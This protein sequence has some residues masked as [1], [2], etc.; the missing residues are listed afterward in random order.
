MLSLFIFI[1]TDFISRI[2]IYKLHLK[3]IIKLYNKNV[4]DHSKFI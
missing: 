3:I 1:K 4:R 2:Y